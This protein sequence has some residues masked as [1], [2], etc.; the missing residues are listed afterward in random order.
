MNTIY[1]NKDNINY[2][3][4][5]NILKN[6]GVGIIPTETVYGIIGNSCS[7]KAIKRIYDIKK[8]NSHKALIVLISSFNM[9]ENIGINISKEEEKLMHKF[10]PGALTIIFDIKDNFHLSNLVLAGQ[11]TIA[12]RYTSNENLQKIIELLGYP[13]VAPSANLEGDETGINPDKIKESFDHKVD[14]FV[15]QGIIDNNTC[16]TLVK[17]TREG[18]KILREGVITKENL[19]KEGFI[20]I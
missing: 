13:V 9:L 8:R 1:Y 5:V 11:D 17:V 2:K 6:D 3:E 10:W 20:V 7:N 19:I 14:F 16:S 15:N 12:I 4:I 18:I